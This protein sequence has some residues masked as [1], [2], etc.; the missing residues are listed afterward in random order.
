MN[1]DTLQGILGAVNKVRNAVADTPEAQKKRINFY[2]NNIRQPVLKSVN[3]L[4]FGNNPTGAIARPLANLAANTIFHEVKPTSGN[5]ST[6]DIVNMSMNLL[7]GVA[8]STKASRI[9]Q[10]LIPDMEAQF[11]SKIGRYM[12]NGYAPTIEETGRIMDMFRKTLTGSKN[13]VSKIVSSTPIETMVANLRGLISPE[14][15][16]RLENVG[17]PLLRKF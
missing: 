17:K 4:P 11:A 5:I 7:P 13:S 14:Q 16:Q 6:E 9:A 10:D 12:E 2:E 3:N 1:Q 8:G 15:M